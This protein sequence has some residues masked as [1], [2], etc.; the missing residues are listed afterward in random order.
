M[1]FSINFSSIRTMLKLCAE[2]KNGNI[3]ER[4]I[5]E[6][7]NHED[8]MFELSRYKNRVSREEFIDY[9]LNLPKLNEE[10]IDNND[11]KIH[12]KY[13][14]YLLDNL[15]LFLDKEKEIHKWFKR[16]VFEAQIN[17]ALKGLPDDLNL[18]ELKFIFTIGI[19]QSFGYVHGNGMH[20]DFLQLIKEKT[21]EAFCST[22]AHEVHHVGMNLIHESIDI[23]AL[24][25][26]SLFYLYFSGEG[27]A[28]KYCNNAE[29]VLSKPINDGPKNIGLDS[30][31]WEYLN[32]DFNDTMKQFKAT[33][34]RIRNNEIRTTEEL[35][36]H[37]E[38]YW[39]NP[40][41]KEQK[42]GDIPKL[43]HFRLYSLGNDIWG[44]IHDCFGKGV[45]YETLKN[46]Q[47]FPSVYN[48]ALR[49]IGRIDLQI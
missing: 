7:L 38:E 33:I 32:S 6:L 29:G 13:Y 46:P 48:K 37:I 22:I 40:L 5:K 15:D 2:L 19:G 18:P 23:N 25:L 31:T 34:R 27:L 47:N 21:L 28:V 17:Y 12:H 36:T 1:Q 44:V 49:N 24:T 8:Y 42:P 41:T 20:F 14:M 43:K 3:K 11:L 39:M 10:S 30:F 4:E 45:V 35:V 26:E 16:D 9:F